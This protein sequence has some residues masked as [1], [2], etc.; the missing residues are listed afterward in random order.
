MSHTDGT[1]TIAHRAVDRAMRAIPD[2]LV[3]R[4]G[5]LF[6]VQPVSREAKTWVEENVYQ[7][8]ETQTWGDSVVVEHRYMS[9]LFDG[10]TDAGLV[11]R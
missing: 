6:L 4:E 2:V 8:E 11:V 3:T 5:A 9:D 10:M 7:D 1:P